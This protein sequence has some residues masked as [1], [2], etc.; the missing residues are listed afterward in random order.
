MAS[1]GSDGTGSGGV[2]S[3]SL[4][5][6]NAIQT[7]IAAFRTNLD[8]LRKKYA[9][10]VITSLLTVS[11]IAS[12]ASSNFSDTMRATLIGLI[13]AL[14]VVCYLLD[15][16]YQQFLQAA[17][18]RSKVLEPTLNV[19]LNETISRI[20]KNKHMNLFIYAMYIG[21]I[22]I[23]LILGLVFISNPWLLEF[24]SVWAVAAIIIIWVFIPEIVKIDHTRDK[25]CYVKDFWEQNLKG[26]PYHDDWGINKVSCAPGDYVKITVTNLSENT[27][28]NFAKD[29]IV[30]FIVD[31]KNVRDPIYIEKAETLITIPPN[32]NYSWLWQ[33]PEPDSQHPE[34][35]DSHHPDFDHAIYRVKPYGWKYPIQPSILVEKPTGTGQITPT[36]QITGT[37]HITPEEANETST[38]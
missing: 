30:F 34:L 35:P 19:D 18:T 26:N 38:P 17:L 15:Y 11:A 4:T 28:I 9:I 37:V 31:Q 20:Y 25:N 29:S 5:E 33:T 24:L 36:N 21:L 2:G 10:S 32:N 3:P 13:I 1:G 14:I 6:W 12:F 23:A 16:D 27:D 7:M 8:D 22:I